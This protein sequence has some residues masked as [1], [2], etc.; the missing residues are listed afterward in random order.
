MEDLSSPQPSPLSVKLKSLSGS[1]HNVSEGLSSNTSPT[2]SN[3]SCSSSQPDLSYSSTAMSPDCSSSSSSSCCSSSSPPCSKPVYNKQVADSCIVRVSVECG[4]N[5]NVYKSIL[6]TSQD[7]SP[8]VI[9]RALD[10]HNLE[11]MSCTDFS[12]TQLLSQDKELQIP[13]KANVFYAMA[14]SANYD[15]V[16]RQ[17]WRSHSRRLGASS[18]PGAQARGRHAK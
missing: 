10:K 1:L 2:P 4:N 9:Q 17:R 15:F 11:N 16:L 18:S 5:G 7:H 14:T 12:L 8:Q 13:D 3:A 6:L